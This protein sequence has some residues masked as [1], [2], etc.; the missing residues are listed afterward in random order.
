MTRILELYGISTDAR[1]D[2]PR[3]IAAQECPF[4]N[5]KCLKTRKSE[6]SETIGSCTVA[7]GKLLSPTVIC[8]FRLLERQQIFTDCIHLLTLH[9]PGN[10]LHI[11]PE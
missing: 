2:W 9:Q 7:A 1:Q 6:A 11:V 8:P 3:I 5:R 10:E 4:L